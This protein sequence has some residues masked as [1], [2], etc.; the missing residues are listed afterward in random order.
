MTLF[1]SLFSFS[2]AKSATFKDATDANLSVLTKSYDVI[3]R[4]VK[5]LENKI[6]VMKDSG[7]LPQLSIL[8]DELKNLRTQANNLSSNISSLRS[9]IDQAT[10]R[11]S[12]LRS[13]SYNF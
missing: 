11:V 13:S 3:L 9:K 6:Q 2:S 10:Q 12:D 4:D 1:V 5:S 7:N 8:Q